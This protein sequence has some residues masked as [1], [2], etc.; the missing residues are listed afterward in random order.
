MA[1]L[2]AISGANYRLAEKGG[3]PQNYRVN[4]H[5]RM[6]QYLNFY[7]FVGET[8]WAHTFSRNWFLR[9]MLVLAARVRN[10]R[11]SVNHE[12]LNRGNRFYPTYCQ[13][14]VTSWVSQ[15]LHLGVQ[16]YICIHMWSDSHV[17]GVW[18]LLHTLLFTEAPSKVYFCPGTAKEY[19]KK[20]NKSM[21]P[22][23]NNKYLGC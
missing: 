16:A 22:N 18:H 3:K 15:S 10:I 12:K 11:I 14:A 2:Y 5:K 1:S 13:W 9:R 6:M 19:Q 23:Q 21:S 7:L 8:V 17:L 20:G 4:V